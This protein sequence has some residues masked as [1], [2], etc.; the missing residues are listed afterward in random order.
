ME[1]LSQVIG[2]IG[3]FLLVFAYILVSNKKVAGDSKFYQSMNLLGSVGIGVNA[4]YQ[5]A[6]PSLVMQIIWVFIAILTLS[7]K[8]N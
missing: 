8:N 7:R 2:W 4:F 1:I 6:W 3:A 5:A